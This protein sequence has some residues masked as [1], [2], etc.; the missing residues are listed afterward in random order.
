MTLDAD[1]I[2]DRRKMRRRL[3]FWRV[4]AFLFLAVAIIS[5][6]GLTIGRDNLTA[7]RGD[8]IARV[9]IEGVIVHNRRQL[10][11]LERIAK[12]NSVKAVL[13]SIES[14]GG[15]VS[16][17][18]AMYAAVRAIA[19][20]KPVV[21]QVNTL[22][23]SAGYMIA[24]AGDRIFARRNAITGSIGVIFQFAE[25]SRLLN[26]VGLSFEAIKSAPLKAEPMPYHPLKP[27]AREMLQS[28][29]KDS[30]DWF[31]ELVG[32]RRSMATL[33]ARELS[34]GRIYSG[35]QALDAKLIDAIGDENA[36]VD[37]LKEEKGIDKSLKVRTWRMKPRED[38]WQPGEDAS[39][40]IARTISRAV[41]GTDNGIK[42]Y[43]PEALALDGLVSVWHASVLPGR[44]ISK[45]TD[46]D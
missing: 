44:A 40:W 38:I 14:P 16:G 35:A 31:V 32:E 43:L 46:S 22:A 41:F 34:D 20:K 1:V 2:I 12:D 23:A 19:E 36:A 15:S 3:S 5:L 37:W 39:N 42:S 33:R 10:R 17:G 4:A 13:V 11:I 8:H 30:Y 6:I 29:V 45:D 24:L 28:L 9:P 26:T 21:V 18:E 27:E 25:A 7:L